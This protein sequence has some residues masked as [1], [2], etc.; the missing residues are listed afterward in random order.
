[1][2]TIEQELLA[3][4][5][6]ARDT[7]LTESA[8]RPFALVRSVDPDSPAALAGLQPGDAIVEFDCLRVAP[9]RPLEAIAVAVQ[10]YSGA[11]GL[12]VVYL[13]DGHTAE[14]TLTPVQNPRGWHCGFLLIPF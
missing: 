11:G 12:R 1:M 6:L 7:K 10:R 8:P 3:Y 4:H 13:R 9:S 14:T 2:H 5:A